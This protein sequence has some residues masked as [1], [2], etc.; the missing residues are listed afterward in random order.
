MSEAIAQY[1][2]REEAREALRQDTLAAWEECRATGRHATAQE[3]DA[4]L[5]SWGSD[6]EL[7][8]PECRE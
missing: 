8:A 4:W 2:D 6:E 5:A 7:P 3:V 1:I